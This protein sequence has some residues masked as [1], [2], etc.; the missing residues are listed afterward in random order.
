MK[1]GGFFYFVL[2]QQSSWGV[3]NF[4]IYSFIS[5]HLEIYEKHFLKKYKK[6]FWS[7]SFLFFGL[8]AGCWFRLLQYSILKYKSIIKKKKN[9]KIVLFAKSKLNNIEVL[10]SQALVN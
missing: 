6:L 5:S 9:D 4:F 3:K 7:V 8:E 1:Y 10:I 2:N